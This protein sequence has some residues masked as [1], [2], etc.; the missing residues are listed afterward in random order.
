MKN[1]KRTTGTIVLLLILLLCVFYAGWRAGRSSQARYDAILAHHA[2]IKSCLKLGEEVC[3]RAV[4][5]TKN[6]I[7]LTDF[8]NE[9]GPVARINLEEHP[10]VATGVTHV[11]VHKESCRTFYLRF[12][13]GLLVRCE[14][15]HSGDDIRPHLPSIDDR[16]KESM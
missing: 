13:D 10:D 15:G 7:S 1:S 11:Y 8:E 9:F 3:S 5:A 14:S 4:M 12:D 16:V 6:S 2:A